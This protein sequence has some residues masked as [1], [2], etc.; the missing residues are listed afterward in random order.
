MK[1]YSVKERIINTIMAVLVAIMAGLLVYVCDTFTVPAIATWITVV[2]CGVAGWA[3]YRVC[4][5]WILR[6]FE[7]WHTKRKQ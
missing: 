6:L 2:L 1:D 3:V 7:K 5:M 4:K